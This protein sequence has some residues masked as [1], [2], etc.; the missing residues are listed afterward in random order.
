MD[1]RPG[2]RAWPYVA[3]ALAYLVAGIHIG[4]P[5][6][7]LPRLVQVLAI[8]PDLLLTDPRPILFVLSG[9]AIVLAMPAISLGVP[10]RPVMIGGI[11]LMLAYVG[12]YV[13]WHLGGHGGFLPG[14]EPLYHG[15]APHEAL[16]SHL[17]GEPLA[18]SAVIAEIALALVLYR[19]LR[20]S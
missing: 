9:I 5:D 16:I 13:A 6:L 11:G 14:R 15:L 4:H 10:S 3:A 20:W 17:I 1:D 8:G 12:G 18:A 2:E 19:G 7:G